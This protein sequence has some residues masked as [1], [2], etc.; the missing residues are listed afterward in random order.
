MQKLAFEPWFADLYAIHRIADDGVAHMLTMYADLVSAPGFERQCKYRLLLEAFDDA[1]MGAGCSTIIHDG[2]AQ[3]VAGV[4]RDSGIDGATIG[5][6]APFYQGNV[7]FVH[8]VGELL[9]LQLLLWER[10]MRA[11]F[12]LW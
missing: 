9:L 6:E 3:A 7:F 2:H 10:A 12:F 8:G 4:A 5:F 1:P 11:T